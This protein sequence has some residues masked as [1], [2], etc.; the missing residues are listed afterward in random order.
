MV[1]LGSAAET[2]ILAFLIVVT[3]YFGQ[4]VLVP[5]ALAVILSFILAPAVRLLRKTGLPKTP[6]VLLVVVFAFAIIF[7]IGALITQQVGNLIEEIP[8]YQLVLKDK[9]KML[10]DAA[11]FSGGAIDRA[12]DTLKDLQKELQK[13]EPPSQPMTVSPLQN[14]GL[15]PLD[16]PIPVEVHPPAPGPLDQLQTL[17]GVALVPLAKAGIVIIFVLFLLLWREDVRDR[18]I[19]LLGAHD[20]EKSTAAMNDAGDRL[21]RYFLGLTAINAAYGCF[22]GVALSFIGV[23]NPILWGVLAMLMR[24]VPFI[25]SFVAAIFPLLVAAAV[26]SGWTMFL[27]TLGLFVVSEAIMGQV[28]EPVVQGNRTGLSPLA[29]I[30]STAFWTLLWGPIGL[31]LAVPLTVVLVVLGRHVERLEFLH[32]MLGDTPPLT[33]AERFYQRMLAGDPA[34]AIEQAEKFINEHPLVDYYDEVMIEGLRLAQ[35]DVDRGTLEPERLAE[36]HD[37][38]EVRDRRPRRRRPLTEETGQAQG[39]QDRRWGRRRRGEAQDRRKGRRRRGGGRFPH[40]ACARCHRRGLAPCQRH[41]VRREPHPARRDG[42]AGAGATP[43]QIWARREG[44]Y[45]RGDEEGRADGRASSEARGSSLLFRSMFAN[46]A[47]T[48]ASWRGACDVRRPRLRSLGASSR[49]I[50]TTSAIAIWSRPSAWMR[51]PTRYATCSASASIR[52]HL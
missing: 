12:S 47:R 1:T 35:S 28:I 14:G 20:L 25:G 4:A 31:L 29:I 30:L 2:A 39:G 36:I 17:I 10:K 8:R 13:P 11:A 38:S 9:V 45:G 7:S 18:A 5:L 48:P 27:A 34:E 6:A 41:P 37:T 46:E 33:P 50:R 3:L 43:H 24:F 21:S 26:D 51:S 52:R 44:H 22:I 32:V 23:P 42:S 15:K 49:S 19:R 40:A 16:R